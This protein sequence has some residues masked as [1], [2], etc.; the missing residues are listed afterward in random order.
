MI[1]KI[2]ILKTTDVHTGLGT[3]RYHWKISVTL[4]TTE[5]HVAPSISVMFKC[6]IILFSFLFLTW[7]IDVYLYIKILL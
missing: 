3:S 4:G 1:T 7:V 6:E 5:I 2:Q